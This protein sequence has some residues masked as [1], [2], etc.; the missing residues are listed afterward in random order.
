MLCFLS[1]G[2]HIVHKR[3]FSLQTLY[4]N[5]RNLGLVKYEGVRLPSDEFNI[6]TAKVSHKSDKTIYH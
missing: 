6:L 4:I 5:I 1:R 2:F 3:T